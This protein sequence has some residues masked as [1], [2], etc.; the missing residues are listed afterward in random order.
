M[1]FNSGCGLDFNTHYEIGAGWD[2]T[3][4]GR[5]QQNGKSSISGNVSAKLRPV[6]VGRFRHK[7]CAAGIR[8]FS[9]F[10]LHS[11][12][13]LNSS[14]VQDEKFIGADFVLNLKQ[15]VATH[16]DRVA[17]NE[18]LKTPDADEVW[19]RGLELTQRHAAAT[20]DSAL[21]E[22]TAFWNKVW[23]VFDIEIEGDPDMLQGLRFSILPNLSIVSRRERRSECAMQRDDWRSVFWLG[24]LGQRNL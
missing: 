19:T 16:V 24:V 20:F 4:K 5:G 10:R 14:L 7:L 8:L 1:R 15:G 2:Q 17:V 23:D 6:T 11:E 12:Q 22:H 9:S 21:A 3:E 18:W 13:A